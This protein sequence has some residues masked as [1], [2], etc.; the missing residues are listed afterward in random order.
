VLGVAEEWSPAGTAPARPAGVHPAPGGVR[1]TSGRRGLGGGGG[2]RAD[3][4][5]SDP[6]DRGGM[7]HDA[8]DPGPVGLVYGRGSRL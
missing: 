6:A 8:N 5:R 3:R 1:A 2:G 4:R 7:V